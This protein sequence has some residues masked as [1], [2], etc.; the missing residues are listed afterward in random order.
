MHY[1]K[2]MKAS[3]T[4][5]LEDFPKVKGIFVGTR[6]TDPHGAQL[7]HF[8]PTDHGWPKFMR[9]HPVIDWHYVDIWTVSRLTSSL[10]LELIVSQ[11]IRHLNIPYCA[12]YDKGYTSLGGTNDTHRN[13]VL[14][15]SSMSSSGRTEYSFR[16]A[17]ELI[18]DEE[19]RLGRETK[20]YHPRTPT[21]GEVMAQMVA[22][23]RSIPNESAIV[24]ED[25]SSF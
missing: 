5:Y 24:D 3:F 16:P 9:I 10:Q 22:P 13:P 19:E 8:D 15:R 17:Y 12:L 4:E 18:E 21:E 6:R 20:E 11:F 1:T 25:L 7:T 23:P 2:P 14:R